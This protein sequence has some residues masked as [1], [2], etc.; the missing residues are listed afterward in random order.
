MA[1]PQ[2]QQL[3]TDECVE[4]CL[5]KATS[6]KKN[7]DIYLEIAKRLL[8]KDN[9]DISFYPTPYVTWTQNDLGTTT[10]E[11]DFR[12]PKIYCDAAYSNSSMIGKSEAVN[13]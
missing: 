3:T 12:Y 10:K 8:K 9:Q 1:N 2:K 7:R 6:D 4:F 5:L 11:P 13:E